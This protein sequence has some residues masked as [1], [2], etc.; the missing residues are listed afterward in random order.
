MTDQEIMKLTYMALTAFPLKRELSGPQMDELIRVWGLVLADIPYPVAAAAVLKVLSAAK[1]FSTL[2][3]IREA[4]YSL[5][6][7]PPSAEEA[8]GELYRY[9][10]SGSNAIR[11]K[12]DGIGPS[13][14]NP[15]L[16][17]TVEQFGVRSLFE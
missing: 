8:W 15:L 17:K 3:E 5:L 10:T 14:T 16:Q 1:F 2:A 11:F 12:Y 4:A 13:F 9:I 6:P 7:G